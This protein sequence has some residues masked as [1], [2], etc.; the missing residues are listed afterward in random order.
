MGALGVGVLAQAGYRFYLSELPSAHWMGAVGSAALVANLICALLLLQTRN[1]GIN[2][3]STWL[4]SRN[5]VIANLGVLVAAALVQWTQSSLPDLAVALIISGIV[6]Q[7]AFGVVRE[8][9]SVT[10]QEANL[11]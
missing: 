3:R 7:S 6:L 5:D 11:Q 1:E 8:S 9:M 2:M 10:A 4:C